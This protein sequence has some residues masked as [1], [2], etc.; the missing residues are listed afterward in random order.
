MPDDHCSEIT[1]FTP[2]ELD[3]YANELTRCLKALDTHAP[4]RMRVQHELTEI[5]AEQDSRART[6]QSAA[7][8][9]IATP[10]V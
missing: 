1:Q 3:R 7:P 10:Q 9:D 4:I 8:G 6:G 2:G 5:R